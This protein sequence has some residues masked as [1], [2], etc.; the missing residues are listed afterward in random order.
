MRLNLGCGADVREGW[1]NADLKARRPEVQ[2]VDLRVTPWPWADGSA[3]EIV[4]QDVLEHLPDTVA[5]F[6][7]A[8][9]VLADGGRLTVRVPRFDNENA[10]RDPT[11]L[12]AFHPTTFEYFDP[13]TQW[14]RR[15][16]MITERKWRILTLV[17][18]GNIMVSMTPRRP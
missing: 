6:D 9:R 13:E 14:G 7:E 3:S 2:A 15:Y 16:G 10:W 5:F 12:R 18:G 4:A 17:D 11:H 8:W 1:V